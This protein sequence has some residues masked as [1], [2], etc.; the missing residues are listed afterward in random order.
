MFIIEV[1][2]FFYFLFNSVHIVS[3]FCD[4]SGGIFIIEYKCKQKCFLIIYFVDAA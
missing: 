1:C 4:L 2:T 3:L